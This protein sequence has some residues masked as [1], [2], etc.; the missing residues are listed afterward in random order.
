MNA[1]K[2]LDADRSGSKQIRAD[3]DKWNLLLSVSDSRRSSVK[4][5]LPLAGEVEARSASG[6]GG[7]S[8]ERFRLR[9]CHPHPPSAP[10]PA[11]GRREEQLSFDV[12]QVNK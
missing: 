1:E 3:E 12:N 6:E 4:T 9:L 11:S 10:S 7:V 2:K 5:P 8:K